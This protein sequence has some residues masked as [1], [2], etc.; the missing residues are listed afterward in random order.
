[1]FNLKQVTVDLDTANNK[2]SEARLSMQNILA[3]MIKGAKKTQ[4]WQ[5]KWYAIE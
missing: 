4:S 2:V 1:M 3:A 5:R